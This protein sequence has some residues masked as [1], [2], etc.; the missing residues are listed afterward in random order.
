LCIPQH[1]S[2]DDHDGK[3]CKCVRYCNH[4]LGTP[5]KRPPRRVSPPVPPQSIG[6]GGKQE[7]HIEAQRA[8]TCLT[9]LPQRRHHG[10]A[11]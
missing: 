5:S 9:Y 10:H 2:K 1:A 3:H 7:D 8:H 11:P 4:P 6:A